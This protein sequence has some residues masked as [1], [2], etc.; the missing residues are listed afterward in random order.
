MTASVPNQFVL[1]YSIS[2]LT[3][4]SV[5]LW[6]SCVLTSVNVV[7]LL[8]ISPLFAC[9]NTVAGLHLTVGLVSF[10]LGIC[11]DGLFI[12]Q[13]LKNVVTVIVYLS[14]IHI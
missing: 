2:A 6:F 5:Y 7:S 1:S 8:L 11:V 3:F 9:P 12:S 13:R 14:L 4:L 10:E